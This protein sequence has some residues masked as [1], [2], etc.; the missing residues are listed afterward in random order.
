MNLQVFKI[1]LMLQLTLLYDY[2]Q[3]I[4]I[5]T[6]PQV[7]CGVQIRAGQT[8]GAPAIAVTLYF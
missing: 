1:F 7:I 8:Y 2:I 3:Y 5:Y 6:K 4:Y